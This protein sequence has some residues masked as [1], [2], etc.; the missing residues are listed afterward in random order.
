MEEGARPYE[1][2]FIP[3]PKVMLGV[4]GVIQEKKFPKRRA[5]RIN[6]VADSLAGLDQVTPRRSRDI[7]DQARAIERQAHKIIR[8]E[9]YIEC[10]CD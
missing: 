5:A 7:C 9:Y 8:Y 2:E 6:F 3:L 1:R 4:I 10:S